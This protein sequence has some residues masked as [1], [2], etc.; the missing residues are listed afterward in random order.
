MVEQSPAQTPEEKP[1]QFKPGKSGNPK[2]A[3]TEKERRILAAAEAATEL[4][5][6]VAEFTE[7][8]GR[9]PRRLEAIVIEQMAAL[10]VDIR[11]R[12]KRGLD[13]S[14]ARRLL[15][16]A[17]AQLPKPPAA[18]RPSPVKQGPLNFNPPDVDESDESLLSRAQQIEAEMFRRGMAGSDTLLNALHKDAKA[19][20]DPIDSGPRSISVVFA[21]RS[22]QHEMPPPRSLEPPAPQLEDKSLPRGEA[23]REDVDPP[24]ALE[25]EEL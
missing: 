20:V 17:G 23:P 13:V 10:T 16:R 2:G 12:S 5:A 21:P 6:L 11:Q 15:L 1:W 4:E 19:Q 24:G 25:Q 22:P 18:P 14:D 3:R 9:P 8:H 7:T